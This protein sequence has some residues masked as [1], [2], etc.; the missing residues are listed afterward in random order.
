MEKVE[1]VGV[2]KVEGDG[3][4]DKLRTRWKGVEDMERFG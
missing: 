2:E 4:D 1:G 3:Q